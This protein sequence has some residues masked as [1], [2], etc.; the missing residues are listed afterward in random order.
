MDVSLFSFSQAFV[1][2]DLMHSKSCNVHE[3]HQKVIILQLD[4][5]NRRKDAMNL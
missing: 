2:F 5:W 1:E 3:A 4:E